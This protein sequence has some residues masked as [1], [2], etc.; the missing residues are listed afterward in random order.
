[1]VVASEDIQ[2]KKI[3]VYNGNTK[4]LF[5]QVLPVGGVSPY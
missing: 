4:N 1:M 2:A 3:T 5:P